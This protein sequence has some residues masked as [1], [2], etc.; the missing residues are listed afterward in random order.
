[1]PRLLVGWA[2]WESLWPPRPGA[3]GSWRARDAQR[4]LSLQDPQPQRGPHSPRSRT[5]RTMFPATPSSSRWH[6][7]RVAPGGVR[8]RFVLDSWGSRRRNRCHMMGGTGRGVGASRGASRSPRAWS[9]AAAGPG[10]AGARAGGGEGSSTARRRKRTRRPGPRRGGG[11]FFAGGD[12][13][14]SQ[15]PLGP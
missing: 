2:Q 5:W 13:T 8:R 9:R 7:R 15:G 4:G 3:R 10:G 1:M 14:S 12:Q 6:G 11:I